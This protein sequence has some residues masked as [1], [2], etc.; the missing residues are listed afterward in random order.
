MLCLT[1]WWGLTNV[2]SFITHHACS[3]CCSK[4]LSSRSASIQ[5]GVLHSFSLTKQ[6]TQFSRQTTLL[7]ILPI[8]PYPVCNFWLWDQRALAMV[9]CRFIWAR[10]CFSKRLDHMPSAHS[11]CLLIPL[12]LLF[13]NAHPSFFLGL[14]ANE[15]KPVGNS[16]PKFSSFQTFPLALEGQTEHLIARDCEQT[17]AF[18]LRKGRTWYTVR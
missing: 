1:H 9:S 17:L 16:L 2:N 5:L 8:L 3:P 14:N 11:L 10:Q 7:F 13:Q 18:T 12:C 6:Q 15:I 4:L